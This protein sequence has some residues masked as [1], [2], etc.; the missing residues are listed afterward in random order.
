[1]VAYALAGRMDIDLYA[2]P[3][4]T[5]DRGEEVFLRDIWPSQDEINE[6]VRNS[7]KTEMFRA[8]YSEVYAG[9]KRWNA[10]DIPTGTASPGTRSRRTCGSP[11]SSPACLGRR[12]SP[13]TSRTRAASPCSATR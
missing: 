12:P 9:D 3:L 6:T 10:L 13:Q 1:M 8:K 7:V 11:P 4:G 5:N 2:E